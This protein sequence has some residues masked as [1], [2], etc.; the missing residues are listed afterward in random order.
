ME[1]LSD[2]RFL[3]VK[4][5]L[6]N[7][8]NAKSWR[9]CK[10]GGFV[11]SGQ[12]AFPGNPLFWTGARAISFSSIMAATQE[13]LNKDLNKFG[14]FG[15]APSWFESLRNSLALPYQNLLWVYCA[16]LRLDFGGCESS[17]LRNYYQS[18]QSKG[19][20]STPA[21]HPVTPYF[22]LSAHS[23]SILTFSNNIYRHICYCLSS[24]KQFDHY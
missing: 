1:F 7:L 23:K 13:F 12:F 11:K 20:P 19:Y 17:R 6:W 21:I 4:P 22:I 15:R 5:F 8:E 3:W 16:T 24:V 9:I 18:L 14:N 10:G 2:A